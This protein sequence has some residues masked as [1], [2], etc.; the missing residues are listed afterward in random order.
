MRKL[1]T[2][3]QSDYENLAN[4]VTRGQAMTGRLFKPIEG[5]AT[6]REIEEEFR[7]HLE[8]LTL[9]HLQQD[10]SLPEATDAALNRFGNVERI[11]DECVE[12]SKSARPLIRALKSFLIVLFL[13]GVLVRIFS[14]ELH[15]LRVG[16]F[17]IVIAALSRL[18]LYVR[19]LNPS[20]FRSTAEFQSA[21]RLNENS[22]L[23]GEQLSL[24]PVERVIAGK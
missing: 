3:L 7:F 14:T 13:A 17:L 24:T 9:E 15:V 11:K 18:F 5:E 22:P 20:T 6:E 21:L 16:N 1:G 12:I 8:M 4:R 2:R 23:S 10:M 19:A